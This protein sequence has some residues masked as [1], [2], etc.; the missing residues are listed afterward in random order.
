M[1]SANEPVSLL[2]NVTLVIASDVLAHLPTISLLFGAFPAPLPE[3]LVTSSVIT[4]F[5]LVASLIKLVVIKVVSQL[6]P[7]P[8]SITFC[9][10]PVPSLPPFDDCLLA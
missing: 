6:V 8:A 9:E 5:S 2:N 3:P 4:N 7:Y 1:P 10:V